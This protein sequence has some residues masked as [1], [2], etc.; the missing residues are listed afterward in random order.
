MK[1]KRTL[2]RIVLNQNGDISLDSTGKSQGRGAYVCNGPLCL[3]MA[4]KNKGLEKSF[5]RKVPKEI[6]QDA[7]NK[8][9][10][11]RQ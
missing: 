11:A 2:L 3:E 10:T 1:E 6:L 8:M 7:E 4:A 5:K 9:Q